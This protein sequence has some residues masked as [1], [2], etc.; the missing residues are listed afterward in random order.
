[1][2]DLQGREYAFIDDIKAGDVILV[3]DDFTCMKGWSLKEVFSD[4]GGLFV[5]CDQGQHYLC[6][7]EDG[8]VVGM[9]LPYQIVS[10]LR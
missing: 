10:F 9:Y 4:E 3:D 8:Y 6:E 7:D 5:Y 1:M 2:Y